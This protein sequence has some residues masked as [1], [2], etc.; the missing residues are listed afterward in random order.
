KGLGSCL[1]PLPD[2]A[3]RGFFQFLKKAS[4]RLLRKVL[5]YYF[6]SNAF[7][8]HPSNKFKVMGDAGILSCM[9]EIQK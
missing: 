3:I 9:E 5:T 8:V 4:F 2:I 6:M 1:P 7:K